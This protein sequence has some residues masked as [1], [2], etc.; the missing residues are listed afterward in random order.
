M[1][2]TMDY[3]VAPTV[4]A[5]A[6]PGEAVELVRGNEQ[7]LL[8]RLAPLVRR[9]NVSLD[10]ASVKRIDA[11]GLAA[12]ITLYTDAAKAGHS[13]TVARPGRHVHEI[14]ALVGLDRILLAKDNDGARCGVR[15]EESAA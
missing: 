11:A 2:G 3:E 10:L 13:F 1:T 14:L 8:A 5:L 7:H 12:L 4:V 15:F 6:G 9:E